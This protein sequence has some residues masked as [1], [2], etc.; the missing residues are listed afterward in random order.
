MALVLELLVALRIVKVH[1]CD[2]R[3][4]L[5]ATGSVHAKLEFA[6][7]EFLELHDVLSKCAS[8]VA[9]DVIDH[10]KLLIKSRLLYFGGKVP[11]CV[12][13]HDIIHNKERLNKVD[14]FE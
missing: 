11:I 1:I 5:N 4:I 6:C 14:H 13:D 7:G 2:A 9:K 12:I 8:L 3:R 10:A